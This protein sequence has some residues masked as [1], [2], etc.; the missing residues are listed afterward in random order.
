MHFRCFVACFELQAQMLMSDS[1]TFRAGLSEIVISFYNTDFSLFVWV[2]NSRV[3]NSP[4]SRSLYSSRASMFRG[5]SH[6]HWLDH[7][8]LKKTSSKV[9]RIGSVCEFRWDTTLL[10]FSCSDSLVC[11]IALICWP[12]TSEIGESPFTKDF[13][14]FMIVF[15]LSFQFSWCISF[16]SVVFFQFLLETQASATVVNFLELSISFRFRAQILCSN[17]GRL[18]WCASGCPESRSLLHGMNSLA[19]MLLFLSSSS[20]FLSPSITALSLSSWKERSIC[21]EFQKWDDD[22]HSRATPFFNFEF[23]LQIYS[24]YI[25]ETT[26][27]RNEE[28]DA[29]TKAKYERR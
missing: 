15:H 25:I 20:S 3:S 23:F 2:L 29:K 16:S 11:C 4:F 1:D 10:P 7:S 24:T 17:A 27:N 22:T 12:K 26:S 28:L 5:E 8:G 18:I 19:F 21:G 6:C 9:L 14:S 13:P